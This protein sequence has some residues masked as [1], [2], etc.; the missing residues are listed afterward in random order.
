MT[1]RP[2]NK[3][4]MVNGLAPAFTDPRTQ[5]VGASLRGFRATIRHARGSG[6]RYMLM[7]VKVLIEFY[8]ADASQSTK[9]GSK[10]YSWPWEAPGS[11]FHRKEIGL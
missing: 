5:G 9:S 8:R 1:P 2:F 3:M 10:Y 7:A 4:A 11:V 6:K